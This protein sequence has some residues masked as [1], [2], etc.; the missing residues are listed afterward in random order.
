MMVP[1][2]SIVLL[3]G[4]ALL[5][6]RRRFAAA[7][8]RSAV[9]Y[10]RVFGRPYADR[11]ADRA[12]SQLVGLERFLLVLSAALLVLGVVGFAG[13]LPGHG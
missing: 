2:F 3:S 5:V 4:A 11:Q 7:I 9:A 10:W 6:R 12:R 13:L 1:G 8:V